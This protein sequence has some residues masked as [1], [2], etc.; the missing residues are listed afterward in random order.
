[1]KFTDLDLKPRILGALKDMQYIELTPVQERTFLH[2]LAGRDII[3]RAETGSGKTA[4]SSRRGNRNSFA[5][6]ANIFLKT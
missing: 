2:I 3:A 6:V 4:A 5:G 1:M